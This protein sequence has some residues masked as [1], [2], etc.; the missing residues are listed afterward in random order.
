[1]SP[2]APRARRRFRPTG[3]VLGPLVL[4]G[5][6]G[7]REL[8]GRATSKPTRA[9]MVPDPAPDLGPEPPAVRAATR[10]R[11]LGFYRP[12]HRR[13]RRVRPVVRACFALSAAGAVALPVVWFSTRPASD[14]GA[15]TG[16]RAARAATTPTTAAPLG[17][18]Q[19]P[20]RTF[21]ARLHDQPG[22]L[23]NRPVAVHIRALGL[24]AGAVPVGVVPGSVLLEAPADAATL[25]WY[26][27][28]PAPGEAGSSVIAGHVDHLGRRGAFFGLSRLDPGAAVTI[29][30]QD[31]SS[32]AWRVVAR[33]Q[34]RKSELP[35]DMLFARTGDPTLA[36]VT[37]GGLYDA[38]SRFYRDNVVVFAVPVT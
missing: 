11:R 23:V 36:L 33:R 31:G 29:D 22:R 37:C 5:L 10:R 16:I 13:R 6:V 7:F 34:Y 19:P 15:L 24:D 20:V 21:A 28:G 4:V 27:H 3:R 17:P 32:S 18:A 38:S 26:E 14:V 9:A 30:Y 8:Q 12:R 35:I 2:N 1:M 25:G